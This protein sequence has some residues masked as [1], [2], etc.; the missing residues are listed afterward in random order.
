M[1]KS[2]LQIFRLKDWWNYIFPPILGIAYLGVLL[3]QSE[4]KMVWFKLLMFFISFL[5]TAAFGFFLNDIFDIDIDRKVRKINFVRRFSKSTRVL[6]II[7][8]VVGSIIPWIYLNHRLGFIIFIFQMI[9][10][11]VYSSP[12][13]RLKN[14]PVLSVITDAFYSSFLPSIIA[15]LLFVPVLLNLNHYNYGLSLLLIVMFFRGLRNILIHH[16]I[17]SRYDK[18]IN[19]GNFA[20]KFGIKKSMSIIKIIVIIEISTFA[21]IL[22]QIPAPFFEY[23]IYFLTFALLYFIFKIYDVKNKDKNKLDKIQFLN[24]FYEDLIP[25]FILILL[26][27]QD[28]R[29]LLLLVVHII[30][31]R[32]KVISFLFVK[33]MYGI[34]FRKSC[35]LI[36]RIFGTKL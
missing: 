17:D 32:N 3:N 19:T 26:C 23:S 35:G 4:L 14:F 2:L 20:L 18:H 31:F 12:P 36:N 1:L 11:I 34:I 30:I 28:Y 9:L 13:I 16:I 10:L 5:F 27:M 29:Y 33:I 15:V 22:F 7:I 6:M 8:V 24:D 25:L 21:I